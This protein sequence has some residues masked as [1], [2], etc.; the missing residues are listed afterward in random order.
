M[1][2]KEDVKNAVKHLKTISKEVLEN[3]DSGLC[4]KMR[5]EV[6]K[7]P[8]VSVKRVA[9]PT[10]PSFMHLGAEFDI[11]NRGPIEKKQRLSVYVAERTQ[12]LKKELSENEQAR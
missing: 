12:D 1:H 2:K 4:E 10:Q 3:Y 6:R 9:K 7:N 8:S 5:E 11:F